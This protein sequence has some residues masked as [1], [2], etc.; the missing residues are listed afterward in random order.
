MEGRINGM[1]DNVDN[2][3]IFTKHFADFYSRVFNYWYWLLQNQHSQPIYVATEEVSKKDPEYFDL[4][5]ALTHPN[6][7]FTDKVET[8]D[9]I[10]KHLF[11][12]T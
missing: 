4:I 11:Q 2:P 9:K 3:I 8:A 7:P 6:L 12:R 5:T 10:C 1:K